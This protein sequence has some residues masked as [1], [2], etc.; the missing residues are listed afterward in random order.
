MAEEKRVVTLDD[1]E[2]RLMVKGLTDLRNDALREGK[3][4]EDV[5]EL[6][7]KVI[8]APSSSRIPYR[9]FPCKREKHTR[10]IAPPLPTE[11][12]DSAG[13]PCKEKRR[14]DRAAR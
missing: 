13:S 3:P 1:F 14:S 4:T 10:S 12:D 7:L 6:I 9:M 5:D 8:D 11:S 2:Q